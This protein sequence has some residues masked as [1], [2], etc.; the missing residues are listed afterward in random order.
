MK[1]I[2][3]PLKK[4]R[5][6]A[7]KVC[8]TSISKPSCLTR[9]KSH[10]R[11]EKVDP[12]KEDEKYLI[13]LSDFPWDKDDPCRAEAAKD[14]AKT[15][16][17]GRHRSY[18]LR[19]IFVIDELHKPLCSSLALATPELLERQFYDFSLW[20]SAEAKKE[21]EDRLFDLT[22][23]TRLVFLMVNAGI[24]FWRVLDEA[25][26]KR[27]KSLLADCAS[28]VTNYSIEEVAAHRTKNPP[29]EGRKPDEFLL[30]P[31]VLW[32]LHCNPVLLNQW[33]FALFAFLNI[34]R[35]YTSILKYLPIPEQV[36]PVVRDLLV[37]TRDVHKRLNYGFVLLGQLVK[38]PKQD[39]EVTKLI[40]EDVVAPC[41]AALMVILD[42]KHNFR[43]LCGDL[44]SVVVHVAAGNEDKS[45]GKGVFIDPRNFSLDTEDEN[46]DIVYSLKY[47]VAEGASRNIFGDLKTKI[48]DVKLK[49]NESEKFPS[50]EEMPTVISNL[51]EAAT[52]FNKISKKVDL[53]DDYVDE[54]QTDME[55]SDYYN[56][57]VTALNH[58]T[59]VISL[60]MDFTGLDASCLLTLLVEEQLILLNRAGA[61]KLVIDSDFGCLESQNECTPEKMQEAILRIKS[62]E[63]N[64]FQKVAAKCLKEWDGQSFI[65]TGFVQTLDQQTQLQNP[66]EEKVFQLAKQ[67]VCLKPRYPDWAFVYFISSCHHL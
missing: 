19:K 23:A 30:N 22:M 44:Q 42:K 56:A 26:Q 14:L 54:W 8:S 18:F 58:E 46:F 13:H 28:F 61:R 66:I 25:V 17:S 29:K 16:Q 59:E 27:D 43:S 60:L 36:E 1:L 4:N 63:E 21:E 48:E 34:E 35:G 33:L 2:L 62:V 51:D 31:G 38:S 24:S 64:A 9:L 67:M 47:W 53:D 7:K 32:Q 6:T 10:H 40:M 55:V 52:K 65:P 50:V 41:L 15:D 3:R 57:Y 12:E 37:F 45:L 49:I 5:T 39:E 11:K 20:F